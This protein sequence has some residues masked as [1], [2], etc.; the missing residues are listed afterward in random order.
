MFIG[1]H[2]YG[3]YDLFGGWEGVTFFPAP[4]EDLERSRSLKYRIVVTG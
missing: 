3:D 2:P 4:N 1:M